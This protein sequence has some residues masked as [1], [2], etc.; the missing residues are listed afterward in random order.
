M[1]KEI[2][3]IKLKEPNPLVLLDIKEQFENAKSTND[4]TTMSNLYDS[5]IKLCLVNVSDFEKLSMS[6]KLTIYKSLMDEI[7]SINFLA[8]E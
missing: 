8:Q 6:D 1:L 7:N 4:Y 3:D 2:R 5:L